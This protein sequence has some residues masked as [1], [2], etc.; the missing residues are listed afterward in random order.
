ML[1]SASPRPRLAGIL[2]VIERESYIAYMSRPDPDHLQYGRIAGT[3]ARHAPAWQLRGGE[4][5]AAIAELAEVADGRADLLAKCAGLALGYGERRPEADHYQRMA[6]LCIAAGADKTLIERWIV[7]GRQRAAS[8]ATPYPGYL[9]SGLAR[10]RREAGAGVSAGDQ[11][12]GWVEGPV[13]DERQLH[14]VPLAGELAPGCGDLREDG[15]AAGPAR[16]CQVLAIDG[17]ATADGI[18]DLLVAV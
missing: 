11:W 6:E 1:A 10:G 13:G 12:V 17:G 7:V 3:A 15:R 2:A 4:K 18:F 9:P 8:G 16:R 14:R 5:A